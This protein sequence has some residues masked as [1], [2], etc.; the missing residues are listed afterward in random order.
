MVRAFFTPRWVITTL[1]VVAAAGMMIR[2]GFWQLE[3]LEQRR[4][5]NARVAAQVSALPLDL[6]K[7]ISR[8]TLFDMEYRQVTVQGTYDPENEIIWRNQVYQNQPGYHLLTP[9]RIDGSTAAIL[10]DRGFIPMDDASPDRRDKY[11]QPGKVQVNGILRRAVVPR[12]FGAPN[13]TLSPGETRIDAWNSLDLQRIQQQSGLDLLPVYIQ[14]APPE[15]A[16]TGSGPAGPP[17]A[18]VE[19]PD[20]SEGSHFGYALQ[21]FAFAAVLGLGYPFFVR[22]QLRQSLAERQAGPADFD[23]N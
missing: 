23:P 6:N 2:L 7:E 19:Q 4:D 8:E 13:P 22:K 12:Y 21:W 18:S 9:L 3:R 15:T 20:L 16:G 1:V 11:A 17:Y 14:L 10:V 5:F